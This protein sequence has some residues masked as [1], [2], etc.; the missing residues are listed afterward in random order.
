MEGNGPK[1]I[2]TSL[3]LN[4]DLYSMLFITTFHHEYIYDL[5]KKKLKKE[6]MRKRIIQ[7]R[8]QPEEYAFATRQSAKSLI[9]VN[10]ILLSG[11]DQTKS[12]INRSQMP[13]HKRVKSSNR[14]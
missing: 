4:V 6:R 2:G 13:E 14:E 11:E 5:Q 9:D 8:L 12:P 10:S 3:E 1:R 7:K